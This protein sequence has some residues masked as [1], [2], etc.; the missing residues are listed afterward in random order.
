M[1]SRYLAL[2]TCKDTKVSSV[3]VFLLD[4]PTKLEWKTGHGVTWRLHILYELRQA[5]TEREGPFIRS[6]VKFQ[7]VIFPQ[8]LSIQEVF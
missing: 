2:L 8:S 5:D 6:G 7:R 4:Q 3:Q 1:Q